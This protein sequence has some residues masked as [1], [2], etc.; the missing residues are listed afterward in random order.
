[1]TGHVR[2][3]AEDL[4]DV[5]LRSQR[6][7][8][9]DADGVEPGDDEDSAAGRERRGA[10]QPEDAAQLVLDGRPLRGPQLDLVLPN[11]PGFC[12]RAPPQLVSEYGIPYFAHARA[13]CVNT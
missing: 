7:G 4:G 5:Y 6:Q 8:E 12:L 10:G 1:M 13:G 3:A 2:V 11:V 9:E